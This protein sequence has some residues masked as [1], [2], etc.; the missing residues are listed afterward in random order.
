MLILEKIKKKIGNFEVKDISFKV[1]DGEILS[2]IGPSGAGKS[3]IIKI[4]TG[5]L[6]A[7]GKI[8][9]NE[10]DITK[11]PSEKR[12]IGYIPQ[13]T[14]LFPHLLVKENIEFP[15]KRRKFKRDKIEEIIGAF[16]DEFDIK[17]LLSRMPETLSGGERQKVA[18]VRALV[19]K[20]ELL[21][22]DEPLSS[23]D[24]QK[25]EDYIKLIKNIRKKYGVSIIYVTHNFDE[26]ITLSE[27]LVVIKNG[28]KIREGAPKE[29]ISNPGDL[30][31]ASFVKEKNIFKGKFQGNLFCVD[32]S[33]ICFHTPFSKE[34]QAFLSLRADEI[35]V[36]KEPLD[37]SALNVYK[38]EITEITNMNYNSQISVSCR[39]V[40]FKVIITNQSLERLNLKTGGKIFIHFKANSLKK[41]SG[42]F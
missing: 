21:L 25:K 29:L 22:M 38:G 6:K 42:D 32:D 1:D 10:R 2:L 3:T 20:P 19:Y 36:S 7:D 34:G 33:E 39:G 5:I 11:L 4:I 13:S 27:K 14:G 31:I 23:I 26:A 16:S 15:L 37:S 17:N 18:L 40:L 35:I 30:W 9:L 24:A 12:N 8:L 41:L 28:E